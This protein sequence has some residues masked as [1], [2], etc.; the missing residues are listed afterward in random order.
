MAF[1]IIQRELGRDAVGLEFVV[2]EGVLVRW[3]DWVLDFCVNGGHRRES[4][5]ERIWIEMYNLHPC[6]P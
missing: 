6:H 5:G 4:W 1:T 2:E 3:A